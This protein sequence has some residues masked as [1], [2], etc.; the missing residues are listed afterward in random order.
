LNIGAVAGENKGT[1]SAVNVTTNTLT[2]GDKIQFLANNI[3]AGTVNFGSVVGINSGN[4]DLSKANVSFN[5]D[6][7]T[8]SI[9]KHNVGLV[10]GLNK[11]EIKGSYLGKS[12]LNSISYTVRANT[13]FAYINTTTGNS[14]INLGGVVGCNESNSINNILIGGR[15]EIDNRFNGTSGNL[16]GIVGSILGGNVTTVATLGLDLSSNRGFDVAGIASNASN[17]TITDVR[18]L[19]AEYIGGFTA[20]GRLI[21]TDIV[22][23]I[24]ANANNTTIRYATVE[25]FISRIRNNQTN[26]V[27]TFYT[28]NGGTTTAGLVGSA[29]STTIE[30]SFVNVNINSK[31]TIYLTSRASESNTYF[32]GKLS[33]TALAL[34]RA[35]TASTY[36]IVYTDSA[37]YSVGEN[38]YTDITDSVD[39]FI[40]GLNLDSTVWDNAGNYNAILVNSTEY[41]FPYLVVDGERLMIE[42]PV[43]IQ[44]SV[45]EEYIEKTKKAHNMLILQK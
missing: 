31:G 33:D 39:E 5:A 37:I 19:S 35:S 2:N 21:G 43:D 15:L 13:T 27:E 34:T 42:K 1:I 30:K 9:A 22:A 17:A 24:V 20:L 11:G 12:S 18:V 3:T 23:S 8:S 38:T 26:E 25:S 4:I 36:S 6:I 44:V 40:A 16:G 10:V 45:D 7:E 28:L 14:S 32:V 41:T 29:T